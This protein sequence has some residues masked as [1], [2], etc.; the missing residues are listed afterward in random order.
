MYFV[1]DSPPLWKQLSPEV[2]TDRFLAAVSLEL[3]FLSS[4]LNNLLV[5]GC[6]LI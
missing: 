1:N 2:V 6:R 5:V 3:A 4:L